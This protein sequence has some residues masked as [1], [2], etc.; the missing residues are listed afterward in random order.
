MIATA[1]LRVYVPASRAADLPA[2]V[3]P[4]LASVIR[5]S[6]H[7]VWQESEVDDAYTVEWNG[8]SY[9]CPR[10]PRLR[11]LEGL[12]AFTTAY[13][14]MPLLGDRELR[15]YADEL[16]QLRSEP[17]VRSYI[18]SS[19]WHVP[20]RWF[21]AFRPA[22]REVY[23]SGHGPAIRYRT[24]IGEAVDRVS[25]AVGVLDDAGFA[26]SV[27]EQVR[28]LERWLREF[29]VESMLELDYA[30]VASLFPESDLVLDESATE[31][32]KSLEALERGD[33]EEAGEFY[34]AVA[35]RWAPVQAVT[36]SN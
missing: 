23:T 19:P 6:D 30:G 21:S 1:Y 18:L 31:V 36:F 28:D 24:T 5:A 2:H 25:W 33:Y 12:L 34:M 10:F 14:N 13:P 3:P 27:I 15:R 11:M 32:R 16:A 22:S 8:D 35:S 7:F 9:S 26:D 17:G 29:G 20:L 4:R